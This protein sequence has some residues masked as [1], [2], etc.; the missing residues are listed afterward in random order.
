[1][2]TIKKKNFSQ[3]SAI[4][5]IS[6]VEHRLGKIVDLRWREFHAILF[7][8]RLHDM[9]QLFALNQTI[10]IDVVDFEEKFDFIL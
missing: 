7:H 1:M 6:I 5:R 2:R 10:A 9:L 8:A 4:I 3:T